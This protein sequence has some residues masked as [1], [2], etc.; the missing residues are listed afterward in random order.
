MK[1][2]CCETFI[3]ILEMGHLAE[4]HLNKPSIGLKLILSHGFFNNFAKMLIDIS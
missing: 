2:K 3:K 4:L 1:K